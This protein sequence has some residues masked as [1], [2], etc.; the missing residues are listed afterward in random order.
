[1][2]TGFKT[3]FIDTEDGV[4]ITMPARFNKLATRAIIPN[5]LIVVFYFASIMP[6]MAQAGVSPLV[7]ALVNSFFITAFSL[8]LAFN[9]FTAMWCYYGR[10]TLTV[11]RSSITLSKTIFGLGVTKK[12]EKTDAAVIGPA[13]PDATG[14]R[15]KGLLHSIGI[16][17]GPVSIKHGGREYFFGAALEE[18]E[19]NELLEKVN[20]RRSF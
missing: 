3:T 13:S 19:F 1:M 20:A 10:E 7:V 12:F 16:G 18:T 11:G 2:T 17:N 8:F 15:R 5:A 9:L 6:S 14:K 4:K